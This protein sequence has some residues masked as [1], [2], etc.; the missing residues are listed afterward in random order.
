MKNIIIIIA[1]ILFVSCNNATKIVNDS[2][3]T[4]EQE[5]VFERNVNAFK[6]GIV[7]GFKEEN[8]DISMDMFADS[9]KWNNPEARL[10]ESKS[11]QDLKDVLT[12]YIENFDDITFKDDVYFG[13]SLYSSNKPSD[14]P[15]AVRVFGNWNTVHTESQAK[16][17]HKWMA[18]LWFN[19]DGKAYRFSDFFD[20]SGLALQI[21][22]TYKR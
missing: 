17:E 16:I 1:A 12:F 7:K 18:I 22:G 3:V 14:S 13:G 11:Y 20:V 21:E 9:L 2:G 8:V 6:N 4:E 15:N 19:E 10:G 5:A